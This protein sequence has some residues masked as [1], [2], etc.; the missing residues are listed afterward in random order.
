MGDDMKSIAK[1]SLSI[2]AFI[3]AS[4]YAQAPQWSDAQAD[5]WAIVQQSWQDDA[6][7]TGRW[8]GEYA[9][10]NFVSWGEDIPAPRDLET[11]TAWERGTEEQT[12]TFWHEITPLAISVQ[13]NSAVVMYLLFVG[14]ENNDGERN[15]DTVN[16]VE[17]LSRVGRDWKYLASTTFTPDYDN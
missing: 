14:T 13:G 9:T 1:L 2:L 8:P 11:Y 3:A 15:M 12:D 16:V 6:A 4:A 17:V 5:V 10:E 7:E